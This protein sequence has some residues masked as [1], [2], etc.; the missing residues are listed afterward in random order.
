M[1]SWLWYHRLPPVTLEQSDI[2]SLFYMACENGHTNILHFLHTEFK[3]TAKD[4]RSEN[5]FSLRVA[6]TSG[7]VEVVKYLHRQF[8]PTTIDASFPSWDNAVRRACI[9]GHLPVLQYIH[10]ETHINIDRV[11]LALAGSDGLLK[12]LRYP[13][14]PV[15]PYLHQQM[16]L[17]WQDVS[18]IREVDA[19]TLASHTYYDENHGSELLSKWLTEF[20]Q[21]Y[22]NQGTWLHD[23]TIFVLLLLMFA[24]VM[25]WVR[26]V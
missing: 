13:N 21:S 24:H 3:L 4:V 1:L 9:A 6:A 15:V 25:G 11:R 16:G 12:V 22:T 19:Y 8:G 20:Y 23:V 26:F 18:T 10:L 5:N 2:R 7:S 17:T 14:N